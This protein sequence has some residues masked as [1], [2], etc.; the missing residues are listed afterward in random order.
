M[1]LA[2]FLTDAI[3]QFA[4]LSKVNS[5]L[6]RESQIRYV[7][8]NGKKLKSLYRKLYPSGWLVFLIYACSAL[9]ILLMVVFLYSV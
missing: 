9:E 4:I 1:A 2:V 7:S 3:L 6:P 8:A 5:K